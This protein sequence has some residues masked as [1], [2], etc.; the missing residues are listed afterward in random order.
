[1]IETMKHRIIEPFADGVI[2]H[3]QDQSVPAMI[4]L[5]KR[6]AYWL[7]P[8]W[9]PVPLNLH[10]LA[11]K[12]VEFYQVYEFPIYATLADENQKEKYL[13]AINDPSHCY[14]IIIT[15]LYVMN[16]SVMPSKKCTIPEAAEILKEWFS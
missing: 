14:Q 16:S 5:E 15:D 3:H 12:L 6:G 10:D 2:F 11:R 8:N 9:A 4:S 13:I 1:M 7:P